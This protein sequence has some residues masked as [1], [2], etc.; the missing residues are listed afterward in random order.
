MTDQLLGIHRIGARQ[1]P[2]AHSSG[3]VGNSAYSPDAGPSAAQGVLTWIGF[4]SYQHPR[5]PLSAP[6][7]DLTSR[8]RPRTFLKRRRRSIGREVRY[9]EYSPLSKA[10]YATPLPLY[11][12]GAGSYWIPILDNVAQR[13][14]TGFRLSVYRTWSAVREGPRRARC[15][16]HGPGSSRYTHTGRCRW[17]ETV[18][19]RLFEG[20]K[21][22]ST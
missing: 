12:S 20:R 21:R 6:G 7:D 10:R 8:G 3:Q 9:A 2:T 13:A 5:R 1:S 15:R 22:S 18:A 19:G 4:R 16:R 17:I 11:R 14:P